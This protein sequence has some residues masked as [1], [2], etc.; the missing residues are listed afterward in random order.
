[1]Y[2]RYSSNLRP[3]FLRELAR[4]R[5]FLAQNSLGVIESVLCEMTYV[6]D[7]VCGNDW[8]AFPEA[9]S[10]FSNWNN[11]G[12]G[13]FL[14][15]LETFNMNGSFLMPFTKGRLS[16]SA[17]HMLR[18]LDSKQVVQLSLVA[19]GNPASD[20]DDDISNWMDLGRE[21]IV[22]GFADLTSNAAHKLWGRKL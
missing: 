13:S 20:S 2:P 21:W 16:F 14:P 18:Q 15:A 22:R 11:K 6:N 12:S 17:Q 19:R 3:R 8:N 7:F 10:L 9:M 4:F 1:M 5:N